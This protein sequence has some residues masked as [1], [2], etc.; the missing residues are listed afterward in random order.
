MNES[1]GDLAAT[2]TIL[3]RV[4]KSGFWSDARGK[5]V[6]LFAE[7]TGALG[8]QRQPESGTDPEQNVVM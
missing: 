8:R 7:W 1:T 5:N 3:L 4:T 6:A 2:A